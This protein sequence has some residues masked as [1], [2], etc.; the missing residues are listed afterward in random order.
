[1]AIFTTGNQIGIS[2]A[3][4]VTSNSCKISFFGGWPISFIFFGNFLI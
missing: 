3:M 1:M 2:L 4:Y